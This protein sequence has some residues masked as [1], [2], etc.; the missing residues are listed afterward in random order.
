MH[1]MGAIRPQVGGDVTARV[2]GYPPLQDGQKK[3]PDG[4]VSGLRTAAADNYSESVEVGKRLD[5]G[6]TLM[7]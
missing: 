4:V 7:G 6:V 5:V 2:D 3:R 1:D